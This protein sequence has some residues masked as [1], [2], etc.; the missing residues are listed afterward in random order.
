MQKMAL[1]SSRPMIKNNSTVSMRM[2]VRNKTMTNLSMKSPRDGQYMRVRYNGNAF[3]G[4]QMTDSLFPRKSNLSDR[5]QKVLQIAAENFQ[6]AK[7]LQNIQST[8]SNRYSH[9]PRSSS[10][11]DSYKKLRQRPRSSSHFGHPNNQLIKN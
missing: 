2:G 7:R 4:F 3:G 6:M 11:C 9:S 5:K 8:F 1:I 10:H